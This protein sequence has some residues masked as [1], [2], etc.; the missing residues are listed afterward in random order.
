MPEPNSPSLIRQYVDG[1]LP[2]ETQAEFE[3]RLAGDASLQRAVQFERALAERLSGL[4]ADAPAA[5]EDLETRI[6]ESLDTQ[7]PAAP[8]RF[9]FLDWLDSPHRAN[10]AAVA[11]C[12][13]LV[14]GAMLWGMLGRSIDQI[15]PTGNMTVASE[16]A[17]YVSNEH[18]RCAN[19]SS[20][21][22]G[23]ARITDQ[24]G[25][26][27]DFINW[28]GAPVAIPD[29]TEFGYQFKGGGHC[30]V[31]GHP[32]SGHLLFVRPPTGGR[33]GAMCSIFILPDV[34]QFDAGPAVRTFPGTWREVGGG[35]ECYH[36][37]LLSDDGRMSYFLVCCDEI[38]LDRL[39]EAVA[40]EI[41]LNTE[42]QVR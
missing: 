16:A 15:T 41:R 32:R 35:P 8:G 12:L 29:L 33:P 14:V 42:R 3:S 37:V 21:R 30:K 25:V 5:P 10:I 26:Q 24:Q 39:A 18:G 17:A 9:R 6:R 28:L 34:G 11:A 7:A 22:T 1:E 38:D 19:D 2:A 31:P 13:V 4:L 20:A 36:T 40:A 23:K 27:A